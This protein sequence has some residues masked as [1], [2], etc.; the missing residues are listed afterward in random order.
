MLKA[1]AWV[2]IGAWQW[3]PQLPRWLHKPL[4]QP[5]QP[6][7]KR[8]RTDGSCRIGLGIESNYMPLLDRWWNFEFHFEHNFR[9]VWQSDPGCRTKETR[10]SQSRPASS[11]FSGCFYAWHVSEYSKGWID[12][13]C[14]VCA[15]FMNW[16]GLCVGAHYWYSPSA[17]NRPSTITPWGYCS[18]N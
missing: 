5:Q 4:P 17:F 12:S 6:L 15:H 1:S 3:P 7:V 10:R 18:N 2:S 11:Q 9:I 13:T 16:W 8:L 14:Q